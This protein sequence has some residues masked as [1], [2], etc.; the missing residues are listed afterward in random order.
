[1]N[2]T[3]FFS[4][5]TV[6]LSLIP[7]ILLFFVLSYQ[8]ISDV[9]S[10]RRAS[11]ISD[12]VSIAILS[13]Q[14]VHELQKER[15]MSAAFIGAKGAKFASALSAQQRATDDAKN[16]LQNL[17][18]AQQ[19]DGEVNRHINDVLSNLE[20][21]ASIRR[22]VNA[23]S[24]SLTEAL[25][26][27]TSNISA[28]LA[29][30]KEFANLSKAHDIKQKLFSIANLAYAKENAGIERAVLSNGFASDSFSNAALRRANQLATKQAAY[31]AASVLLSDN[32]TTSLLTT[33]QQS[34]GERDVE[35]Y[36]KLLETQ[37]SNFQVDAE[38]W[39]AA[40]TRRINSLKALQDRL[41][42]GVLL[43]EKSLIQ[44]HQGAL[45]VSFVLLLVSGV[46][47]VILFLILRLTQIQSSEM[48]IAIKKIVKQKDLSI[49]I[50]KKSD[51]SLGRAAEEVNSILAQ[52]QDDLVKF[53]RFS[54]E[55]ASLSADTATLIQ[56]T[57]VNLVGQQQHVSTI[58]AASEQ[59]GENANQVN[60]AMQENSESVAMAAEETQKGYETV[61]HAIKSIEVLAAEVEA[62]SSSIDNLST[63]SQGIST[64][65]NIIEAIAEQTN[66]L[67]LNAA[68]EAAR[69]GEQ[70]RGFAVVA[71]EVRALAARTS[72]S[73]KEISQIV[74]ALQQ[75]SL[76]ANDAIKRGIS[77]AEDS[78]RGADDIR[79][80][81]DSIVEK[82][83]TIERVAESVSHASGEQTMAVQE[84]GEKIVNIN[85]Q[86][87]EN[88]AG[89][90][91]VTLSTVRLSDIAEEM[92]DVVGQYKT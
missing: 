2:I 48:T 9:S 70:G 74:T 46:F 18:A 5:Y 60:T 32:D 65:V 15:G 34:Q 53:Q 84:I 35:Q 55:V 47:S 23:L 11:A 67:A 88:V 59:M 92:R 12:Q 75:G 40:S 66:L 73:T 13:N 17:K 28:L 49:R 76:Q 26:Y 68:I 85:T 31:L 51:D 4:K 41:L 63:Q 54:Q 19:A 10:I 91:N 78:A 7:A 33:F 8:S 16:K 42:Q 77:L 61:I 14:L 57:E 79:L 82:M 21:L 39:F 64:M 80:V 25:S 22:S 50:N 44:H 69:A 6:T 45:A 52:F 62:L 20:R 81:L 89:V 83:H 72:D 87:E 37:S 86:A 56:Q 90:K 58:S 36:R 43:A 38:Q 1:M 24:V 29:L 27:Y 3:R 71:D 30:N